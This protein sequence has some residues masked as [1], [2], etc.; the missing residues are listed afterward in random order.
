MANNRM[1]LRCR[2]CSATPNEQ[3]FNGPM[4]NAVFLLAKKLGGGYY[5]SGAWETAKFEAFLDEH[6][7]CATVDENV[8]DVVYEAVA[9]GRARPR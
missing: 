9:E 6:E 4:S 3:E 7:A 1:W 2:A 5:L 8:F